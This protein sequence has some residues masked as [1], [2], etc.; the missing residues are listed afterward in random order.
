[1]DVKK[2]KVFPPKNPG[3][4]Q[5]MYYHLFLKHL[6]PAAVY[7]KTKSFYEDDDKKLK[8]L[9][10]KN[11]I[12]S[13][14]RSF[15]DGVVIALKFFTKRMHFLA[16]DPRGKKKKRL[17]RLLLSAAGAIFV[18]RQGFDY[19]FIEKANRRLNKGRPILMFP[20]QNFMFGY[21]P[22]AFS[23]GYIMLA[24]KTG[25]KIVPVVNDFNYGLFK[26]VHIMV[27]KP[28]DLSC[29]QNDELNKAR[30]KEI[31][32]EV[33]GKFLML[34]NKLK[35]KKAEKI[36]GEYE[37]IAPQKG[38][39]IRVLG[40]NYYHYGVYLNSDEVIQ[41]GT[42]KNE[43][44]KQVL[45]NSVSLSEF[46]SGII[47]EV[48]VLKKKQRKFLRDVSDIEKYAKECIGQGGYC[49]ATN[50]CFNLANRLTLKL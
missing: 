17:L 39:M 50:N 40:G 47:P 46:C 21:E 16:Y 48:R 26:R 15:W 35:A 8:R 42:L 30:L 18:D 2:K 23:P 3:I 34:N 36:V 37:F 13:N 44:G 22:A 1:L 9:K 12:I 24:I 11:I 43:P 29:Y 4:S 10:G 7:F 41:F 14:H 45:V 38:D 25:A 33:R 5:K 49:L 31:N 20:E 27:G 19:S 28:I 32:D 6:L